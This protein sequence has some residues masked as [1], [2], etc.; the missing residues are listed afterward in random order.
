M[1]W[2]TS[3]QFLPYLAEGSPIARVQR[4]E[5][6]GYECG[7][8]QATVAPLRSQRMGSAHLKVDGE[9]LVADAGRLPLADALPLGKSRSIELHCRC[10]FR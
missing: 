3:P 4:E 7:H 6:H 5:R 8:G 10:D 1:N 2:V 9:M